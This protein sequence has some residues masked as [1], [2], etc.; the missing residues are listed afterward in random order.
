MKG[1]GERKRWLGAGDG[2]NG[3]GVSVKQGER[4]GGGFGTRGEI[5][6]SM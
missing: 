2:W 6:P 3:A 5:A 4:G 1:K